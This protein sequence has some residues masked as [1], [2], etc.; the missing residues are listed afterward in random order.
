[1]LGVNGGVGAEPLP[2]RR[3]GT[4][5]ARPRAIRVERTA[6]ALQR[7][8]PIPRRSR[9]SLTTLTS[10]VLAS[11]AVPQSPARSADT[12]LAEVPEDLEVANDFVFNASNRGAF[13]ARST[14][15]WSADGRT[16]AYVGIRGDDWFPVVGAKVGEAYAGVSPPIL[17]GGHAFFHVGRALNEDTEEHWL[18]ID[19][20]TVGPED[21]MGELAV[22]RSGKQVAFW[23]WP[24]AHVGNGRPSPANSHR[25]A[26]ASEGK[27]GHWTVKRS[28]EWAESGVMPPQFSAD[29]ERVV[30][31]AVGSK[32]WVLLE[33]SGKRATELTEPHP[34]IDNFALAETSS[35]IAY[36]RTDARTGGSSPV[37]T[38]S[39]HAELYFKGKRVGP[40]LVGITQPTADAPGNHVAC[41]VTVGTMRAVAVDGEV[42]KTGRFDH[43]LELRFDPLGKQLAFVANRGGKRDTGNPGLISGGESFVVVVPVP[44]QSL[45]DQ[46]PNYREVRDLVW[47]A[48]G[49]RLAY[50]AQDADGWRVVCGER[51][52][53]PHDDVGTP[54]FAADGKSLAFGTRDGRELWW[55][56]HAI[57]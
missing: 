42:L 55:R 8:S 21:W 29:G 48:A 53:E 15:V 19:G 30:A 17:A 11:A 16:V 38:A 12:L 18:W 22:S 1:V 54:M 46:R 57:E 26:I 44:P 56:A 3:P 6:L 32:G 41:V 47:N 34:L 7:L 9:V 10:L 50:C 28:D 4:T 51:A 27:N 40:K 13:V 20:K 14:L 33:V 36:V 23:T 39:E 31:C 43:V 5:L 52:S 45:L 35:A 25:L 49:N 24:G 37:P 2:A